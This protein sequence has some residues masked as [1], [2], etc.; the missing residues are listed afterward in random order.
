MKRQQLQKFT[1]F[2]NTLLPHETKYLLSIQQ[3][4]DEDRLSILQQIHFN[5]HDIEQFTPYDTGIDKRKYNHI[6][7]WINERLQTIDVDEQFKWYLEMEQKIMTD[8]IIMKEEK[9]LL[10]AIKK[11]ESP[12]FYFTRFY[13][14]IEH[15][16][17]F[18]LIRIRYEDYQTANNFL[19][20][21][22][23][24]YN[25]T[26]SVYAKIQEITNDI[27]EQ[28]WNNSK[29]SIQWEKWLND[30]FYNEDLDGL[31]RYLALVRLTFI[32][33][34]YRN[35][36]MVRQQ[37]D[38]LDIKY[39]EGKLY[40]KR[41]LLNYYNN[42]LLMHSKFH[43]YDKAIFFGR[44]SVRVKNHDYIYYVNNL[45]A[46]LLKK[47]QFQEALQLM[48]KAAPEAKITKN[49]HSKIGFVAFYM[50]AMIK[51]NLAKNAES[52]GDT[53]IRAYAKEVL[54]VRWHLFFSIYLQAMIRQSHFDKLLK[55]V[56]KFKLLQRDKT[57]RSKSNHLPVIPSF[58]DIAQYRE[59]IIQRE[60][61]VGNLKKYT[62]PFIEEKESFETFQLLKDEFLL[63]IPEVVE[64]IFENIS[65][66]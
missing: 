8:S 2:T 38:Y 17:Q 23:K 30:V 43:E 65:Y 9:S 45:C 13:E 49:Y 63:L 61:L 11:Y 1:E 52:Y 6:Q 53:L 66:S 32:S 41:H 47:H 29:E 50:Q 3:F 16:C 14:V 40:S 46:V 10:R 22:R 58:H 33:S 35:F 21:Y 48:K 55:T 24:K 39:G 37:F 54:S 28:Y 62:K 51:N 5:C 7:N 64:E 19:K 59:G 18:L 36:E 44:L 56:R 4:K 34:N 20:K 27:I 31:N 57:Y 26:K 15:Y 12:S 60:Q 42:R 25:Q